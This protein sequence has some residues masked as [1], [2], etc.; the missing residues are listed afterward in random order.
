M[1]HVACVFSLCLVCVC[2]CTTET[3]PHRQRTWVFP[4]LHP[5][6]TAGNR[7]R[8]LQAIS[9]CPWQCRIGDGQVVWLQRQQGCI[10][11]IG[12]ET[13]QPRGKAAGSQWVNL[14]YA[15]RRL[16]WFF[17]LFVASCVPSPNQCTPICFRIFS[18]SLSLSL[19]LSIGSFFLCGWMTWEQ[20]D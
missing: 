16:P 1:L 20:L 18:L 13:L 14:P 12:R 9:A 6:S 17:G 7:P 8:H 11:P 5:F 10:F 4:T 2:L 19:F 15:A 3:N